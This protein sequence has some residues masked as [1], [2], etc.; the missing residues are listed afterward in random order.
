MPY[1]FSGPLTTRFALLIPTYTESHG[2]RTPAYPNPTDVPGSLRFNGSFRTFG[3]TERNVNGLYV[4]EDT[5]TV[6]TW[7]RPD[8]KAD[9]H[10]AILP[11]GDEYEILGSPEDIDRRHQYLVFKVRRV[12]GG[13]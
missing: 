10:I 12:A 6:E 2:V 3:G 7:Y 11:E 13:A 8:I 5:G 4:I 9:C 1:K